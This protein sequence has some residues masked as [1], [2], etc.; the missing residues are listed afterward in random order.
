MFIAVL[1]CSH[2]T[3]AKACNGKRSENWLSR[4]IHIFDFFVVAAHLLIPDNCKTAVLP[5]IR[6]DIFLETWITAVLRN[7][8]FISLYEV[9]E[10][11]EKKELNDFTFK[12]ISGYL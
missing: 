7:R 2:Y 5:N 8:K 9:N 11:A 6:Y 1:L 4:H 3:H 10:T 12:W